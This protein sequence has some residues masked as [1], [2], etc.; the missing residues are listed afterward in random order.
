MCIWRVLYEL[1][2]GRSDLDGPYAM[3]EEV[4]IE[5]NPIGK[6]IQ[7]CRVHKTCDEFAEWCEDSSSNLRREIKVGEYG[8]ADLSAI[9]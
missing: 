4:S 5:V 2:L 9:I 6:L 3:S 8:V 1:N 7:M